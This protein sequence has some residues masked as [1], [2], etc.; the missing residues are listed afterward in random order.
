MDKIEEEEGDERIKQEDTKGTKVNPRNVTSVER[1]DI[2]NLTARCRNTV[3]RKTTKEE[4]SKE[5]EDFGE[6]EQK[7]INTQKLFKKEKKKKKE[8]EMMKLLKNT[9]ILF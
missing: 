6:E 9:M 2:S 5:E 4:D 8:T 1:K 3:G 7:E